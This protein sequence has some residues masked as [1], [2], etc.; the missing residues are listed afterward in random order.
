MWIKKPVLILIKANCKKSKIKS[1][2]FYKKLL[3]S[4]KF[5]RLY[6]CT[7][8]MEHVVYALVSDILTNLTGEAS[9]RALLE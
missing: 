4:R 5:Y 7:T 3:S 6:S 9:A 2:K 8:K 1:K